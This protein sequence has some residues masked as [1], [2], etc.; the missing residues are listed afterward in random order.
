MQKSWWF[1]AT[2]TQPP[3]HNFN[4]WLGLTPIGE[5]IDVILYYHPG[6]A[7]TITLIPGLHRNPGQ[8]GD[9]MTPDNRSRI[10]LIAAH[11]G[12]RVNARGVLAMPCVVHQGTNP[13]L[14]LRP[15]DDDRIRATCYSQGCSY[16]EI[17]RV[18]EEQTGVRFNPSNPSHSP[19]SPPQN[20]RSRSIPVSTGPR[21]PTASGQARSDRSGPKSD[22][23]S[24]ETPWFRRCW[25][26]GSAIPVSHE[27]PARI[28]MG[29]RNL[30]RPN[31]PVPSLL[32]WLPAGMATT[33]QHP[34]A[35]SIVVMAA[36]PGAWT[37]AWPELPSAQGAQAIAI[38]RDGQPTL[39]RP[40][41]RGGLGKRT[42]QGSASGSIVV[43]GCPVLT[44]TLEPV[45]VA[46]GLADALALASR[47]PG[48]VVATLG[49][50]VMTQAAL[51]GWLAAAP[52]G[53]VVH[54]DD[55]EAREGRPPAGVPAAR[56]LCRNI[57]AHGG[58]AEAVLPVSGKD[59][60]DAATAS[61]FWELP[62]GWTDYAKTLRETTA[63]PRWE[64]ARKAS[65]VLQEVNP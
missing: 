58:R 12:R 29:H 53:V 48:P 45:R 32:R 2:R 24:S 36:P 44:D 26:S 65:T 27:H 17:A 30:W 37:E 46:E 16:A 35:G 43:L 25:D 23:G 59:A 14:E 5:A 54:A 50:G 62:D 6:P 8:P 4:S 20:D 28:W 18:I 42:L 13:K 63:W 40:A 49:K 41:S 31:L 7:T 15:G 61:P 34:G 51:A 22:D 21:R 10:E 52:A 60:A 11:Y 33:S 64:I 57:E 1:A 19:F 38:A 56:A 55:D 39:D 3:S 47:Y 9:P